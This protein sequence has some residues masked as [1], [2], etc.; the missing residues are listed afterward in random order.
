M[1]NINYE[2]H[3]KLKAGDKIYFILYYDHATTQESIEEIR[4][5]P[6]LLW[7]I[8]KIVNLH[9]DDNFYVVLNT[10]SV[11]RYIKPKWKDIVFKK[12][13]KFMKVIYEIPK[14]FEDQE[15]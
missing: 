8:G 13:I 9:T 2:E 3:I 5:K 4:E 10:G 7:S 1:D 11:G 12:A 14:N 15:S 6:F